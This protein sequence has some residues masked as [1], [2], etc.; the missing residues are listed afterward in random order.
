MLLEKKL[1]QSLVNAF[2]DFATT[3]NIA[4]QNGFNASY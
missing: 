4:R 2:R 1:L 3:E